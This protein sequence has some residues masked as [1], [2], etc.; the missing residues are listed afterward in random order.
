[1]FANAETGKRVLEGFGFS[2]RIINGIVAL[3]KIKGES[4]E[5]YKAKVKSNK[6]AIRVKMAD[7]AP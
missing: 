6:D 2:E 4:Y 1:M 5:D 7:Y 3:T